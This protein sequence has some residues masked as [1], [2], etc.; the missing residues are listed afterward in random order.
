V[1]ERRYTIKPLNWIH[2]K[3]DDQESWVADSIFCVLYV[4]RNRWRNDDGSWSEWRFE[5]CR[6]EYYCE[7]SVVVESADDGKAKAEAWYL[8]TLLPALTEVSQ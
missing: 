6:D 2:S 1:S 5:Y 7:D 4:R 3:D 8:E